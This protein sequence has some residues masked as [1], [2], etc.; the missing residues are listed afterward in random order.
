MYG[1]MG[2]FYQFFY[3][4]MIKCQRWNQYTTIPRPQGVAL[5]VS[6]TVRGHDDVGRAIRRTIIRYVNL[7][8]VMVLRMLSPELQKKLPH[9]TTFV[10]AELLSKDELRILDKINEHYPGTPSWNLPLVWAGTI[11][12]KAKQVG[13]IDSDHHVAV[14]I[15]E[16]NKI[17]MQCNYLVYYNTVRYGIE[18]I[19]KFSMVYFPTI[20]DAKKF[21]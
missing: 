4:N 1:V 20:A 7:T 19:Q 3:F 15:E 10:E 17:R 16:L 12:A 13:R 14:I 18:K 8:I 9:L 6:S 5:F 21:L 11:V 2:E